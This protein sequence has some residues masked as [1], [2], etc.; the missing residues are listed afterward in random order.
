MFNDL[1][2]FRKKNDNTNKRKNLVYQ[3]I[4]AILMSF[5]PTI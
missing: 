4:S 5:G 2:V 3:P 1:D